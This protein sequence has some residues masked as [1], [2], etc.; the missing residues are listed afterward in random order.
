M[1]KANLTSPLQLG[2]HIGLECHDVSG[3]NPLLA[4]SIPTMHDLS[5]LRPSPS[6]SSSSPPYDRDRALEPNMV[7]TIEPGLYFSRYAL[8]E[9]YARDPAHARYID[10][11]AA[12]RY[13]K[14]G[15]VR[16]ED[17]ILVTED[18]WENLTT[19][20]KGEEMCRVVREGLAR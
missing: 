20:P 13:Y 16:I 10:F 12:E 11:A 8:T 2:H 7:I 17:D 1:V 6:S 15:G 9:V 14:V 19:A 3:A 18:G 4:R 5:S